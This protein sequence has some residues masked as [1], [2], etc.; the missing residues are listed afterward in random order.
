[1]VQWVDYRSRALLKSPLLN[2]QC[3]LDS[4]EGHLLNGTYLGAL[5]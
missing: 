4:A 2:D 5:T 1:M 3:L